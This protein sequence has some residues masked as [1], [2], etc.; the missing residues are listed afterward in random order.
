MKAKKRYNSG[1][2]S[3]SSSSD[4]CRCGNGSGSKRKKQSQQV[5]KE[6][7]DGVKQ[8]KGRSPEI[9][10]VVEVHSNH[11]SSSVSDLLF[12]HMGNAVFFSR[13]SF[14]FFF[15]FSFEYTRNYYLVG[16]SRVL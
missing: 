9:F 13:G 12:K 1:S 2:S 5:V 16:F 4:S 7:R 3:S 11:F 8:G 10:H 6:S 15:S 14:Q